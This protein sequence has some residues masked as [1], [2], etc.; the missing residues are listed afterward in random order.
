VAQIYSLSKYYQ[1][2]RPAAGGSY[3]EGIVGTFTNA[4]P[5]Y[6]ASAADATVSKLLFGSLLKYDN[7]NQL[8]GD[9]AEKWS[10]DAK[11]QVYTVKLRPNLRW[12]DGR[13]L[14]AEDVVFTYK[15]IQSPD[16]QSPLY[17]SW[18][19]VT[20]KALD[21][22]TITFTL[23]NSLASF[24]HSLTNGIVPE[25]LLKDIPMA[26]MR[27]AR[28]NTVSPIG[29]GPFKWQDIVVLNGVG[30]KRSERINLKAFDNYYAGRP[31]LDY[32][33]VRVFRTDEQMITSYK[34]HELQAMVGL[35]DEP[36]NVKQEE[37]YVYSFPQT[38]ATMVF[39]K[40]S[41]GVLGD[42]AVRQALV[43]S[44]DVKQVR[45]QLTY[46]TVAVNEPILK[47]QV[48]YDPSLKQWDYDK[49]TAIKQLTEG[50]WIAPQNGGIRQKG[51]E[52]LT[53]TLIAENNHENTVVSRALQQAWHSV[54]AEAKVELLSSAELKTAL[55]E[56]SYDA[57]LHGISIGAD[58]DVFVYW[59]SSQADVLAN[60]R[61]NFSEYKSATA[62][63]ALGLGR[64]RLDPALRTVKYKPFLT[65]W[66]DDTPALGL[67]QPRF[68]YVTRQ[69]VYGLRDHELNS[70]SDR[71]NNVDKWMIRRVK[72][73]V[74]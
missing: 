36:G 40:M 72:T 27:S 24:P 58:P 12:H 31:K 5:L 26:D 25:H 39:F 33:S 53:F 56:H 17:G 42:K 21:S 6:A 28:F 43:R 70:A 20:V 23:A 49:Q 47:E 32:Y 74:D 62:D 52:H 65:A 18:Q 46:P 66:H 71:L 50:G 48:G 51:S 1:V 64:T 11:G 61:L 35:I 30:D 9:L 16:A 7:R 59:H 29:S 19:G 73:E 34:N 57:L 45:K 15:V 37:K 55:A 54:G 2:L 10:T 69:Q 44:V 41:S 22:R 67:Y 13:P 60:G 63:E 8:V 4:N 68:L 38:A 14:T 3:N